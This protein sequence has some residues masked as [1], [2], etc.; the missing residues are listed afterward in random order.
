MRGNPERV[1][2]SVL[3][4]AFLTFC[5]LAVGIPLGTRSFLLNATT[6]QDAQMQVIEGT[7]LVRKCNSQAPIGVFKAETLSACDEV[8]TDA[9]SWATLDLFDRSHVIL[10]SNSD[11]E[12]QEMRSPRF[13]LSDRPDEIV[14]NLTGGLL[15]V[16]VA[17]PGERS[18]EFRIVTPHTAI[19]VGDG[20]YRIRVDNQG[21]EVTVVRGQA[22]VGQGANYA[23]IPQSTRTLVDLSGVPCEP[24]PSAVDLV[25]NGDFQEPLASAWLTSTEVLE[26]SVTPPKVELVKDGGRRA[27]RLVRREQDDGNH[28]QVRIQQKLDY[29]VRDFTRLEVSMDVKL[30]FQSLSGGGELS[31]EFPV[32]VRVDYKDRWGNDKFWTHGFYYQNQAGY[33]IAPDPWGQP[34]GEQIPRGVWYPYESG[35]LLLSLGDSGPVRV[36]GLTVYA[37]GWNYDSLVTEIQLVVE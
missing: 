37:S 22:M 21:T 10:Y 27:V 33:A 2:W 28:N 9:T 35:N 26:P 11:L 19:S 3:S 17:P 18:T 12:L 36:T 32:I 20:S 25:D 13:G 15:R 16:G 1:A 29:D 31:S 23:A 8:I 14:L 6:P 34:S 30:D 4:L 7:V 24:L 5:G